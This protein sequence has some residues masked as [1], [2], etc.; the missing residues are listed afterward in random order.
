MLALGGGVNDTAR[1]G[2]RSTGGDPG[3]PRVDVRDARFRL[4]PV[5]EARLEHLERRCVPTML[6]EQI[7]DPRVC[8]RVSRADEY[9]V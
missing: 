9:P 7:E 8:R 6:A 2:D 5:L 3:A 4:E 1:G